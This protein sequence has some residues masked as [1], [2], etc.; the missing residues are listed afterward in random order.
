VRR[1]SAPD[2]FE[3]FVPYVRQRLGDDKHLW[4]TTLY[5]EVVQL[6][7]T[8]S[9]RSFTRTLRTD[10]ERFQDGYDSATTETKNRRDAVLLEQ[11]PLL[12]RMKNLTEERASL[13][14]R[15]SRIRR[16]LDG[17]R[18]PPGLCRASIRM[19]QLRGAGNAWQRHRVGAQLGGN[20]AH[21]QG[22]GGV[23][24][25]HGDFAGTLA[26]L[27]GLFGAVLDHLVIGGRIHRS[28]PRSREPP[29]RTAR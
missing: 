22:E 10:A 17:M 16:S 9:Y 5:D 8:G 6:G 18:R 26:G 3:P 4:A 1:R 2:R 12:D 25:G 11:Y 24:E 27:T 19:E 21:A 14:G 29:A 28:P 23:G 20:A 15:E 13:S 7:Y